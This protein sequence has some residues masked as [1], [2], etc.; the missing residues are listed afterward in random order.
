MLLTDKFLTGI[1]QIAKHLYKPP[2]FL[3][4]QAKD[5]VRGTGSSLQS[6]LRREPA[7]GFYPGIFISPVKDFVRIKDVRGAHE[8]LAAGI[9]PAEFNN[10]AFVHHVSEG[11][12]TVSAG[13]FPV[14]QHLVEKLID[15]HDAVEAEI[16]QRGLLHLE[17]SAFLTLS[18]H[19]VDVRGDHIIEFLG[20]PD[21]PEI[22]VRGV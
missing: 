20:N 11:L 16:A 1:A 9:D 5:K 4:V 3:G 17:K 10:R 6:L 15:G 8:P 22:L 7:Q 18:Q 2:A 12:K 13:E 14:V 21:L 19:V